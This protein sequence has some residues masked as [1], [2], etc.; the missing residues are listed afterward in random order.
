M[1]IIEAEFD[2][3]DTA[4][5]IFWGTQGSDLECLGKALWLFLSGLGVVKY[6]NSKL[7]MSKGRVDVQVEKKMMA[8]FGKGAEIRTLLMVRCFISR[9]K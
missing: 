1:Q 5:H 9:A 2:E 6:G 8:K 7:N 3:G 4:D